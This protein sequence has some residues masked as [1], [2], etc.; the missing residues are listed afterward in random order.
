M[1][2]D[3]RNNYGTDETTIH[4]QNQEVSEQTDAYVDIS[5]ESTPEKEYS[6]TADNSYNDSYSNNG[7]TREETPASNQQNLYN[8]QYQQP[9]RQQPYQQAYQ[10]PFTQATPQRN[11]NSYEWGQPQQPNSYNNYQNRKKVAKEKKPVSRGALALVLVLSIVLAAVLGIGGGVASY[12]LLSNVNEKT[13]TKGALT[14]NKSSSTGGS[15]S[16]ADGKVLSTKEITNKVADSVVE[17]TTE[18]VSYSYFYGQAVSTGAGS[19]VIIDKDGYIITNNHVIEKAKSIKVTLRNG[20]E[21]DAKLIGTDADQDVALIKI[22][23]KSEEKLTV[24]TFGDSD[25]LSVGDKAVA[26]GNPLGELGGTVTDGIISALDREVTIDDKK[27]NL[28]QTDSAINPGNSGGGLFDGQGNLI[29]I[30][31]AKAEG[32]SST[33]SVEGLG[34][35]I[36]INDAQNILS[37][38]KKYGYVT[39]KPAAIGVT[40]QDYMNMVYVYSVT[41]NSAADKAGI[42]TGDKIMK[43]DGNEIKSSSDVKNAI[44]KSKA[45]DKLEF[46]VERKGTT[47][48]ITITIEAAEKETTEAT[49]TQSFFGDYDGGSFWDRYGF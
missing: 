49:T 42:Q 27:M 47:K 9:Y 44:S 1:F 32:S 24:A 12:F 45:G 4:S 17:I 46:T 39:N 38:L 34:F 48:N 21:Y 40:L 36:P 41:E 28:L 3:E 31:V 8:G 15:D 10:Q 13:E 23:P 2:E 33:G 22:E 26:I 29:G 37:D 19:G 20:N 30:V 5:S 14:I 25:K 18:T 6:N 11:V 7:F 35:A 16:S 43:V